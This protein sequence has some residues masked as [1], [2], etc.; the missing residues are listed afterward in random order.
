VLSPFPIKLTAAATGSVTLTMLVK[1]ACMNALPVNILTQPNS[2]VF[3]RQKLF[4]PQNQI[5]VVNVRHGRNVTLLA[6]VPLTA[7]WIV[8]VLKSMT[9]R[10]KS[11]NA[12]M[13]AVKILIV[14]SVQSAL[15]TSSV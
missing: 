6:T 10:T 2:I 7:S 11:V 8:T 13:I 9:V 4:A 15:M 14:E 5:L 3:Q 1:A 12:S